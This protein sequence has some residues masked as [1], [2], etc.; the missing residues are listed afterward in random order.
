MSR[1]NLMLAVIAVLCALGVVTSQHH[2][3][4]LFVELEHEQEVTRSLEVEWGQLQL[5]QS[6]WAKH[7]RIEKLAARP[8]AD[9][10]TAAGEGAGRPARHQGRRRR[11]VNPA[12]NPA[13]RLL[14]PAWRSRL[15]LLVLLA[16]FVVLLGRAVYLQGLNNDF[17]RER[18]EARYARVL[19]MTA[20]RGI[21][22][23]RHGEPLAVSTASRIGVG[24]P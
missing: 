16:A 2:A 14:L 23:D 17:L 4:K 22:T 8:P 19:E 9:A 7:A 20:H 15:M 13:L 10:C 3:R 1:F 21:I 18:G 5:E 11:P 24:E 12:A 6:T